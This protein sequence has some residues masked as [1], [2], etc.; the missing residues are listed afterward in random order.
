MKLSEVIKDHWPY[1]IRVLE[2]KSAVH[3][4]TKNTKEGETFKKQP[5]FSIAEIMAGMK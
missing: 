4:A 5:A 2:N 1:F 3:F